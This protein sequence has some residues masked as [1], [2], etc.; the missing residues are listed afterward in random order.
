YWDDELTA[1]EIDL[2]CGVYQVA[3]GWPKP[4]AWYASGLSTGW[5]SPDCE[6]WYQKR[7]G[8]IRNDQ[9]VLMTQTEWK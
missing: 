4:V 8:L 2:I 3:T 9:G 5:W 7:L 1:Q 6:R